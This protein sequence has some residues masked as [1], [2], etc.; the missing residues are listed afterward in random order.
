[1]DPM[2]PESITGSLVELHRVLMSDASEIADAAIA[3]KKELIQWM[4]WC[5]ENYSIDDVRNYIEPR[6]SDWNNGA[7]YIFT[8]R[9]HGGLVLGTCGLN[10]VHSERRSAN[11]G[12]WIATASTGNGYATEAARLVAQFGI[13]HLQLIRVEIVVDIDN[14]LSQKVAQRMGAN[15]EGTLVNRLLYRGQPRDAV[16]YSVTPEC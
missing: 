10:E 4:P 6:V 12:Y 15:R 8:I 9:D 2:V 1:M 3:S 13:E 5:H 16:M 7:E 14:V 11:L